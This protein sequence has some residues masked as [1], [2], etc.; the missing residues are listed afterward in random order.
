[1][2][3]RRRSQGV[4]PSPI[5]QINYDPNKHILDIQML[6]N[7]DGGPTIHLHIKEGTLALCESLAL[8]Y[9]HGTIDSR[10]LGLSPVATLLLDPL[11]LGLSCWC[12]CGLL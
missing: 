7:K 6:I 3:T 1:M 11:L 2:G 5:L 10:T 9:R 4:H 12:S 8:Y